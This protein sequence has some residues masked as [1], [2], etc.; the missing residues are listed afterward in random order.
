MIHRGGG[1]YERASKHWS[2]PSDLRA[3]PQDK[4]ETP[5]RTR[6]GGPSDGRAGSGLGQLGPEYKTT[7][8]RIGCTN[9]FELCVAHAD[10]RYVLYA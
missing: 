8:P 2:P 4:V 3:D 1:K 9:K 7:C 6:P 5:E 10:L